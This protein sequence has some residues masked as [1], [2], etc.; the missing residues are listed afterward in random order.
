MPRSKVNTPPRVWERQKRGSRNNLR[1]RGWEGVLTSRRD[2]VVAHYTLTVVVN[3]MKLSLSPTLPRGAQQLRAAEWGS[4]ALHWWSHGYTALTP[5][6]NPQ[7]GSCE[8]SSLNAVSLRKQ[9]V[10]VR[11]RS[12]QGTW[13]K[14]ESFEKGRELKRIMGDFDQRMLCMYGNVKEYFL[15]RQGSK[16]V[17]IVCTSFKTSH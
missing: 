17:T 3:H 11:G 2:A 8:K 16:N 13:H 7:P 10:K 1:A 14:E 4:R 6:T 12:R 5:V 9:D 15:K